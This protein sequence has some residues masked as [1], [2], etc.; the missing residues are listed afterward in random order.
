MKKILLILSLLF[1]LSNCNSTKTVLVCGDHLC[2][3]KSEAEQYFEDNLSLEVRIVD[4]KKKKNIN[5]VELNLR[6][7]QD[8]KKKVLIFKKDNTKKKVRKLSKLE[9]NIKKN[10]IRKRKKQD[11]LKEKNTNK[12]KKKERLVKKKDDMKK[13]NEI[14][15]VCEVLKECSIDQISKYLIKEGKNKKFPDITIRE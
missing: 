11:K 1:F 10:E 12:V 4:K 8:G 5:L 9:R 13:N 3:N 15:D 7:T 2:V 14:S 6:N